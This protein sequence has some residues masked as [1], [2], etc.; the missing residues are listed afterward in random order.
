MLGG[1]TEFIFRYMI[2]TSLRR[3]ITEDAKEDVGELL[4]LFNPL[5]G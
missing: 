3:E 4:Q 5:L 2:C 1:V